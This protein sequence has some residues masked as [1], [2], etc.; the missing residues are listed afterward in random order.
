MMR[1]IDELRQAM[2]RYATS[3]PP[4]VFASRGLTIV[5]NFPPYLF[6]G[7]TA[8]SRWW[9]GFVAHAHDG[10]LKQLRAT[11]AAAY[12]FNASG[13]R[14]FFTLPT[15]WT[16][17]TDGKRFEERGGWA[18]VLVRESRGWRILSY[19]WAVTQQSILS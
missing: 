6:E 1:P 9:A 2:E 3:A 12:D 16:G 8:D 10:K 19:G 17:Y 7:K 4:D 18:F 15:T 11:F 14:V 5:E 13:D